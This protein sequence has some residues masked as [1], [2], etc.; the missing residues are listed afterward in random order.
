MNASNLISQ[1][2]VPLK[3]SNT[4]R[5]ALELMS[6]YYV[7]HLPIVNNEQLLGLISEEDILDHSIEEPV[8]SYDLSLQQPYVRER[9]HVFDVLA[10]V[11]RLNLTVVPVIDH[12]EVYLGVISQQSLLHYFARSFSFAER[13]SIIVLEMSKHDYSLSEIGRVVESEGAT[14]I[15]AFIS[16]QEDNSQILVHLKINK[17]EVH[18]VIAAMERFEYKVKAMYVEQMDDD[19]FRDRFESFMHYLNV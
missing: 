6:D 18:R 15:G 7:Q 14:V 11:T 10:Q 2:I 17:N 13:G 16:G 4:G 9:D 8:G 19:V 5:E 3:T 12:D 1:D